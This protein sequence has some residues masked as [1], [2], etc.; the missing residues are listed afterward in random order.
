MAGI[1]L[2]IN[3]NCCR[4]GSEETRGWPNAFGKDAL[5][6]RCEEFETTFN[7]HFDNDNN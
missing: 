7:K 2:M 3:R 6:G 4:E 1:S 5:C